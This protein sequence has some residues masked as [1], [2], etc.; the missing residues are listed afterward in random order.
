M[1]HS[2]VLLSV[3]MVFALYA[4]QA[5]NPWKKYGYTPP[6][7]LTLSDGKYEEFFNND[8]VTQIG[9]VMFNTVTNEVVAFVDTKQDENETTLRPEVI[10][11]FLSTDPFE[12]EFPMLS[13]YL[14][15]SLNPIKY[16]DLDGLE[17]ADIKYES[18]SSNQFIGGQ[19]MSKDDKQTYSDAFDAI[20]VPVAMGIASE[21]A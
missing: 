12:T 16:I 19:G 4:V 18:T 3:I 10:S 2:K 11:R 15:A 21:F 1:K 9:S 20:V 7:A 8:T 14:F 5:Q 6:K 13:P 17:G